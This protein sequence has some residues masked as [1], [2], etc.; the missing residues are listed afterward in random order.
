MSEK[1]KKI[2][3]NRGGRPRKKTSELSPNHHWTKRELEL[4]R[5]EEELAAK[6]ADSLEEVAK[7]VESTVTP[8]KVDPTDKRHKSKKEKLAAQEKKAEI[9]RLSEASEFAVPAW[10]DWNDGHEYTPSEIYEGVIARYQDLGLTYLNDLD[11]DALAM[12]ADALSHYIKFKRELAKIQSDIEE[13]RA[14]GAAAFD[15][16]DHYYKT[17]LNMQKTAV[18]A[19]SNMLKQQSVFLKIAQTLG[20]TPDGRVKMQLTKKE[21]ETPASSWLAKIHDR[22]EASKA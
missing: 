15:V 13:L 14:G 4:R 7:I 8:P 12:Y 6:G 10:I 5:A 11:T 16:A 22:K 9:R 3:P 1:E 19:E 17:L 20:L 2:S 21:K 18:A